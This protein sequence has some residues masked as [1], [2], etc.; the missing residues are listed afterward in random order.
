MWVIK[1]YLPENPSLENTKFA[2][3]TSYSVKS[4]CAYS[5]G[6]VSTTASMPCRPD[7]LSISIVLDLYRTNGFSFCQKYLLDSCENSIIPWSA[8]ISSPWPWSA[9]SRFFY[10][11]ICCLQIEKCKFKVEVWQLNSGAYFKYVIA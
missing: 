8:S 5:V 3:Y 10:N 9:W 7:R 2:H 6:G 1:F 11:S 4:L